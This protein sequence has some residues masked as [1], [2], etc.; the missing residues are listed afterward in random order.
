[1]E[2][3][4]CAKFRS[5]EPAHPPVRVTSIKEADKLF[6]VKH[7]SVCSANKQQ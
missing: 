3:V 6:G 5:K 2:S 7:L 4:I 1:M